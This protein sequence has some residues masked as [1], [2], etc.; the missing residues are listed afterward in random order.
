MLEVCILTV[1][2]SP[3]SLRGR[4]SLPRLTAMPVRLGPAYPRDFPLASVH[5]GF[6]SQ[7]F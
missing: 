5:F 1:G 2:H 3:E 7:C 4:T 6:S